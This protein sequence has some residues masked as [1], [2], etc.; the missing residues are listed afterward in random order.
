MTAI[1]E[2][3]EPVT[4]ERRSVDP[5]EARPPK[6]IG[7]NDEGPAR[8]MIGLPAPRSREDGYVL[9]RAGRYEFARVDVVLALEAVFKR[10][11][12]L[13]RREPITITDISQW[14][15]RRPALDQNSPRHQS[16]TGG[17]DVDIAL[18][19]SD[20]GPSTMRLHCRGSRAPADL[21]SCVKGSARGL[22]ALRLAF[23]LGYLIDAPGRIQ[24]IFLDEEFIGEVRRAA[25]TLRE[26]GWISKGAASAIAEDRLLKHAPWHTD[27]VHVRFSGERG[28]V[29]WGQEGE[30]GTDHPETPSAAN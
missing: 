17:R 26:R 25:E 24:A 19:A 29:P 12:V 22:D 23:L 28:R 18:P 15:G 8:P 30:S 10:T 9:G 11:R 14:D 6:S 7:P 13:F 16:H 1:V 21:Y 4:L 5:E 3:A 2:V 27:H 20:G